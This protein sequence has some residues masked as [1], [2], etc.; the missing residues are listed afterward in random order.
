MPVS[1]VSHG[2]FWTIERVEIRRAEIRQPSTSLGPGHGIPRGHIGSSRCR[3]GWWRSLLPRGPQASMLLAC[4]DRIEFL[5]HFVSG[6]LAEGE[7]ICAHP[8]HIG[9][10]PWLPHWIVFIS[11]RSRGRCPC[12][13]PSSGFLLV[14]QSFFF[15]TDM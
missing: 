14:I 8:P 7:S 5:D 3:A 6:K 1:G 15:F 9:V 13:V 11:A 2:T 10:G 12:E 4:E